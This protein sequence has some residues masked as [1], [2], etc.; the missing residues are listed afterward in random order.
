MNNSTYLMGVTRIKGVN[1]SKALRTVPSMWL[2]LY[3]CLLSDIEN[4][5]FPK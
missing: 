5:K 3:E 4:H 1:F 2:T